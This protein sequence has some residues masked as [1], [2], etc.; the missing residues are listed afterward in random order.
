MIAHYGQ[1]VN[2]QTAQNMSI[3]FDY[4]HRYYKEV[5]LHG[6]L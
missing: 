6:Q 3:V 4:G 2:I 5:K 1:S